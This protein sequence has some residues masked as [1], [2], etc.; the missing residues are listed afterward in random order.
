MRRNKPTETPVASAGHVVIS[1]LAECL[2]PDQHDLSEM[3]E[4]LQ[5]SRLV[6]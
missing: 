1:G 4:Q 6:I 3:I 5:N 2:E